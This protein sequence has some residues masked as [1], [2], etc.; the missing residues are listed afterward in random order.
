MKPSRWLFHQITDKNYV[1]TPESGIRGA[2][3]DEESDSRFVKRFGGNL[4]FEGKAALDVGCGMGSLC[5]RAARAGA[6][7]IVGIDLDVAPAEA[8]IRERYPDVAE[9]VELV[10]TAG[11]LEELSGR[12][13][14]L[15]TSKDSME[16]FPDP[17]SFVHLLVALVKP[18]GEL[19]IGFSPLWKSP[20]GGHIDYMTRVPW[21]HLLFSEET[22]MAERR[23]FRPHENAISFA[24]IKGGLNKMTLARFRSIMGGTELEP[25]YFEINVSDHPAVKAMRALTKVRPLRE[26]FTQS[27]YS[28]WRKP[29]SVAR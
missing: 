17:E 24:E 8:R 21:A 7:E 13:F 22:I 14:D 29:V 1:Y 6:S 19:A 11:G 28:I 25:I 16:H 10:R 2:E 23:R 3:P 26:Y 18:G 12:Q 4:E 27:V 9:R 20:K 5:A 15:V